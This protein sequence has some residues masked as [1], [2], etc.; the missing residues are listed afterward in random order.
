MKSSLIFSFTLIGKVGLTTAIPLVA[1]AFIGRYFDQKIGHGHYFLLLGMAF[2]TIIVY[3][4]IKKLVKEAIEKFDNL[5][6]DK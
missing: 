2:A 6:K 4:S 1:F 5:N 3:F